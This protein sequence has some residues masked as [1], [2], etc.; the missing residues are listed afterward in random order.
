[1]SEN[2]KN[3]Q[4]ERMEQLTAAN[5]NRRSFTALR[6][7]NTDMETLRRL[8]ALKPWQK[9]GVDVVH[10]EW[11][12]PETKTPITATAGG[13]EFTGDSIEQGKIFSFHFATYLHPS[14]SGTWFSVENMAFRL[15]LAYDEK[16]AKDN[17]CL[18]YTF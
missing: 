3:W 11:T 5:P 8:I 2:P 10:I 17:D 14:K 9:E 4:H 15:P 1:M 7:P 13:V 18:L 6:W 16:L 12:E